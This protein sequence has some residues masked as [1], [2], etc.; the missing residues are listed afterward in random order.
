MIPDSVFDSVFDLI[1]DSVFNSVFDSIP[2]SAFNLIFDSS[3]GTVT[4]SAGYYMAV[5]RKFIS[6][7]LLKEGMKIDQSIVDGTGRS[8]IEKGAYLD[9]FHIDYLQGKGIGGVYIQEGEPDDDEL[10]LQIPQYT[11]ELIEKSRVED[12]AK[13]KL[14]EDVR[15]RVGEGIQ[16]LYSHTDDANFSEATNN[17]ANELMSAI[18]D[19]DAVAIDISMLKVSDEYTFKHSVDVAT[20]AMIV[21][22]KHGLSDRDIHELGISGLLHDVGKSK[23]PNEVLNKAGRLTDE[24]FALMKQHTLF[25]FEILKKRNEF[26]D[27]IMRGVLQ[28]HEKINGKGYPLG[29]TADKIHPY[30]KI[31]SVADIYDALVTERPYKKGFPK[32]VAIEMIMSM[33]GELDFE[34]M[35]SFL[36][37]VILYSVDSI[38]MLSNGERAKVV[39][40]NPE[41]CLRPKVVG[42]KT[43]KLYDLASDINCASLIIQ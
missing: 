18:V 42:L 38:V 29:S 10:E 31:I 17:V 32:G 43:G 22:K 39:E 37:S 2:D 40:N 5:K 36:S 1:P 23:I 12:R 7:R 9:D 35:K 28:H 14:T 26:S 19:N 13:V 33:T 8:L 3:T 24:E 20:M 6:T 16:F 11:K 21:G 34:A 41:N 27:G 25:G 4:R 30:A 15:Q